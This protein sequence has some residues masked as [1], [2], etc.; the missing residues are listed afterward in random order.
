MLGDI[1]ESQRV[2]DI[3]KRQTMRCATTNQVQRV[4]FT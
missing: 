3:A 4:S 2:Q 1:V